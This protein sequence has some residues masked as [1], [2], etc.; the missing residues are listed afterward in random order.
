[1]SQAYSTWLD[2]STTPHGTVL[3]QHHQLYAIHELSSPDLQDPQI[4]MFVGGGAKSRCMKRLGFTFDEEVPHNTI[5][6]HLAPDLGEV[7][8]PIFLADCELHNNR[9]LKPTL[10][11]PVPGSVDHRILHWPKGFDVYTM[12]NIV[13]T[14]LISPF[15]TMICL[16]ADDL[17]GLSA[18]A[19]MLASW[20]VCFRSRRTSN[21]AVTTSPRVIVLREWNDLENGMFD[22]ELATR[23]FMQEIR[24]QSELRN[25]NQQE[26]LADNLSQEDLDALL[27]LQFGDVRVLAYT[28]HPV[29]ASLMTLK[30]IQFHLRRLDK[31]WLSLR[32]RLLQDSRDIQERRRQQQ[33]AF[34]AT[35]IHALFNSACDHIERDIITPFNFIRGSRSA[36]PVPSR[37]A[38]YLST[39]LKQTPQKLHM[40][41]NVPIIA[42]ALTLDSFPPNMHLFDAGEVFE[43]HYSE[44]FSEVGLSV[45]SEKQELFNELVS[46]IK[47]IFCQ[48]NSLEVRH[49][50]TAARAHM[51]TLAQFK[52][53]WLRVRYS[54]KICLACLARQAQSTLTCGHSLCEPCTLIHGKTPEFWNR[55]PRKCPL[56]QEPNEIH[57][58]EK[59]YTAGVRC[60][61]VDGGTPQ[62]I[63]VLKALENDLKLP[64]P[65]TEHFDIAVGSGLLL[66]GLFCKPEWT[67]EDCFA[68]S[69][70]FTR[71]RGS[72]IEGT[73]PRSNFST[74]SET[75]QGRLQF[76]DL[77][78]V[79]NRVKLS[80]DTTLGSAKSSLKE[81]FGTQATLFE[82]S[83]KGTKVAVIATRA[84]DSRECVFSNFNASDRN[85]IEHDHIMIRPDRIKDELLLW[86]VFVNLN[87][88]PER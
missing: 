12:A 44:I 63:L 76:L 62:D 54:T 71:M 36:N 38:V 17:E 7:P 72:N 47:G 8:S 21:V 67:I 80:H 50:V 1:M 15:S 57:F 73:V 40:A 53:N 56:C 37:L 19:R 27:H 22:E 60:L 79:I 58:Q 65:I 20:L 88:V 83:G 49:S 75:K 34:S 66:L 46:K 31:S 64:A 59:P 77:R 74:T 26:R 30:D 4:I 68:F 69:Q 78:G 48:Q 16:F 52:P 82:S 18:V 61:C 43:T 9:Q 51:S 25:R 33:V 81:V 24:I 5:Q 2:L 28:S 11:G 84:S 14:K 85:E 35:H 41:F 86:E 6:L 87:S 55:W 70:K 23:S 42:S 13:Y 32:N 29:Y 45:Y 3:I 10:A 39:F